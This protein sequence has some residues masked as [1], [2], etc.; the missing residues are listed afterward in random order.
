MAQRLALILVSSVRCARGPRD[1]TRGFSRAGGVALPAAEFPTTRDAADVTTRML[2][3]IDAVPGVR[4]A[5]AI[6]KLPL[7]AESR[8]DS[9]VYVED[10][11]LQP[12]VFP[13]LHEIDF[14]TPGYFRAMNI[15]L[16][17]GRLFDAPDPGGN[18]AAGPPEVVVSAAFAARYWKGTQAIG[19]RV[20]MNPS[21]MAYDRGTLATCAAPASINHRRIRCTARSSH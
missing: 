13:N 15:P 3:A 17:A 21:I 16:V 12:G 18:P 1:C 9:A 8:Q 5:G 14:A 2:G 19:K 10:H 20:R 11:P 6:T 4:A 7:D